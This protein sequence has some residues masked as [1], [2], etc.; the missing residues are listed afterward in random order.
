MFFFFFYAYI[1]PSFRKQRDYLKQRGGE[2]KLITV[3]WHFAFLLFN[4]KAHNKLEIYASEL[5][6]NRHVTE[7]AAAATDTQS[8]ILRSF[9]VPPPTRS[10][11]TLFLY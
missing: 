10:N 1:K 7:A 3:V 2:D 6:S 4:R 5:F 9:R 8:V 11:K